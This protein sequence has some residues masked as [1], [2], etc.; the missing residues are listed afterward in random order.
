VLIGTIATASFVGVAPAGAATSITTPTG[1]PFV[2]PGDSGG[3][4]VSFTVSATGFTPTT[5]VY[6]EQCDG[7]SPTSLGWDPTT[8]CDLGSSPAPV[9]ADGAGSASFSSA[10]ANHAFHPFKGASPQGLFNCLS[11]ND[12]SPNNGLPD[13]RNCQIRVSSNNAASTSD[14]VFLSIALP[15]DVGTPP[16]STKLGIGDAGVLEGNASTRYATFTV[17]LSQTSSSPVTVDYSTV[18]GTAAAGSDFG[19]KTGSVA[20]PAGTMSKTIAIKIKGD[21][22]VEPDETF[23]VK[24]SNPVGATFSRKNG[25][26][27]IL[28]DD[29][30]TASDIRAGIGNASV[31]EG[32]AGKR[33]LAF[34]VSLSAVPTTAVTVSY[35]T[36][37]GTATLSADFNPKA[38][39]LVI[40]AGKTSGLIKIPVKGDAAV[41]GTETLKVK[42]SSPVGAVIDRKTGSGKILDDD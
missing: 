42:I 33:A 41:E 26:G 29:P 38:A 36:T 35:V 2:V 13:H 25:T 40:A 22:V 10:D 1:S 6:L 3:N 32:S 28:N 11:P 8:N 24:L 9:V 21:T 20:I 27:T 19:D 37:A 4:P 15:D 14:Q 30:P 23:K 12:P 34:T 18:A 31:V 5:N 16:P 17:S 7:V 39:N